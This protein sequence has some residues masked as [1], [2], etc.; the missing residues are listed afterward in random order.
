MPKITRILVDGGADIDA[1]EQ[2]SGDTALHLAVKF[3]FQELTNYL[4]S[5]AKADLVRH[6]FSGVLPIDYAHNV[7]SVHIQETLLKGLQV[8][9]GR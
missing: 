5:E 9:L 2:A 8:Q 3:Q 4:V 1:Q 6:N 7:E